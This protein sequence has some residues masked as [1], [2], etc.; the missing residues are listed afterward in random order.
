MLKHFN[1]SDGFASPRFFT[2]CVI[3]LFAF[4][5][6]F[7]ASPSIVSHT[8]GLINL[9]ELCVF[10]SVFARCGANDHNNCF[11]TCQFM[12]VSPCFASISLVLEKCLQ[13]KNPL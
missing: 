4:F 6:F 8:K 9:N 3:Q 13:P 10:S 2:Y 7:Y 12:G 1:C 5:N 11:Y